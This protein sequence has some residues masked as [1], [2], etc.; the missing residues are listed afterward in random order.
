MIP[1]DENI[2][3]SE[4]TNSRQQATFESY[5]QMANWGADQGLQLFGNQAGDESPE[6]QMPSV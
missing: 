4:L 5:A 6:Q 3:G 2:G 1:S